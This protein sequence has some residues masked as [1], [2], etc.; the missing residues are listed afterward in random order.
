MITKHIHIDFIDDVLGTAPG[1]PDIHGSYVS[2]KAPDAASK[3]EE[4]AAIGEDEFRA[5][6]KTIF[7]TDEDGT[8]IFYT[9][10]IKG[11]FKSACSAEAMNR[12]VLRRSCEELFCKGK[13]QPR[14]EKALNRVAVEPKC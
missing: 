11:F 12:N 8:P 6:G 2:S 10:Q 3:E 4:I 9:Y 7:P 5:K 14:T 13:E 1:D